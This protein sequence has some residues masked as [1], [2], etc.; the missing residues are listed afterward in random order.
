MPT[1]ENFER[2]CT[3]YLNE[4]FG[5]YASFEHQGG[6]NS[7]IPDICVQPQNGQ[8]FYIEVK[9]S[10]A[11]CGQFVLLPNIET[12]SFDY[13]SSNT[14]PINEYAKKIMEYMNEDFDGFREAGTKGKEIN[15]PEGSNIFAKWIIQ[16]YEK[17]NARFF[18]TNHYHLIPL[19]KIVDC[20]EI[21][22][23]YR[24]KRSGSG[25]VG[26]REIQKVKNHIASMGYSKISYD[27]KGDKLFVMSAEI[28]HNHRFVFNG[29]KYMFSQ[30]NTR[31][32]VRKLSNTYNANVI[33]SIIFNEK[34]GGISDQEFIAYLK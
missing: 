28:S 14:T 11:Q 31:F 29:H 6:A 19:E 30:R 2:E 33:F 18:I 34:K 10:P 24:I 16:M 3:A 21:S 13:S 20:F 12:R 15:M 9:H 5:T 23:K 1:W 7:T 22:A 26:V 25:N 4:K 32:E 8:I 27:V 17:K